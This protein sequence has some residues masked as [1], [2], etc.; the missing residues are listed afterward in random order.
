MYKDLS[1]LHP[2]GI[3][4]R[5]LLFCRRTQWSLC[6]G[7]KAVLT[8][9][10]TTQAPYICT[11]ICTYICSEATNAF[12]WLFAIRVLALR[13]RRKQSDQMSVLNRPKC[14]PNRFL[15][16]IKQ[17]LNREKS[18]PIMRCSC[19]FLKSKQPP[20]TWAKFRPI[21]SPCKRSAPAEMF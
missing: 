6:H 17:N 21:W 1:T 12:L 14:G 20:N 18:G 2:C 11:Y 8:K 15:S 9:V 4:T 10:T 5:D 16:K 13:T 19:H 7:A 3:Q